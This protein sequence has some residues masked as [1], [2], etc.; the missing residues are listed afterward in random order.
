MYGLFITFGIV[1]YLLNTERLL[2]ENNLNINLFWKF[3]FWI[4]I[5]GL[6]GARVYYVIFNWNLFSNDLMSTLYI[7]TG[8]L[9]I[10]GGLIFGSIVTVVFLIKNDQPI[11]KWSDNLVITLPLAQAIGRWGNY[12]NRE[13]LPY[14]I[15]ES[16]FDI[17]LFIFLLLLNRAENNKKGLITFTYI[18]AYLLIRILLKR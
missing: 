13:L 1:L 17:L 4:I 9:G 18:I 10:L 6:I 12:F 14:A 16:F 5:S 2:K 8:G 7:W 15:Y 11:L 3:S